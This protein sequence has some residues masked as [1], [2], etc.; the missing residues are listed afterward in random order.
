MT[1]V[2]KSDTGQVRETNQDVVYISPDERFCILA[3]GMGGHN[4]GNIASLSAVGIVRNHLQQHVLEKNQDIEKVLERT[5][6]EANDIIHFMSTHETSL[7]GMG[8][9]LII[10]YFVGSKVWFAH[11]GDSRAYKIDKKSIIQL[12]KDHTVVDILVSQGT[13]TAEEARN[14]PKKNIITRAVGTES[15]IVVDVFCTKF[16]KGDTILI[17][18][19]GL[20]DMLNDEE[21][22][23]TLGKETNV[24]ALIDKANAKGGDDNISVILASY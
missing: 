12:T 2:A 15:E 3:D 23:A 18:S 16:S 4:G 10:C 11:V 1:I 5:V 24:D 22:Y 6:K 8:T 21:L 19:D 20:T 13:I 17:C 14:H 9:T 7:G